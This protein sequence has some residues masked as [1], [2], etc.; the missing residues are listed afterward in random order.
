MVEVGGVGTLDHSIR[1]C[2]MGG[3]I[4]LVGILAGMQAPLNLTSVLMGDIRIQ[5][6]FVGPREHFEAMNRAITLHQLKPV[7][8]KVFPFDEAREALDYVGSG[9]HFGK[10]VISVND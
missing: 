2:R 5:G 9:S 1:S 6:V 7:V 10:V 3:H 4:S 8:D